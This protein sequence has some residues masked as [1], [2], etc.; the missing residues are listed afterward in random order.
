MVYQKC[1]TLTK[2]CILSKLNKWSKTKENLKR[3]TKFN[4]N[5]G[6][7][8]IMTKHRTTFLLS[9]FNYSFR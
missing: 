5:G 3:K 1:N 7:K 8:K 6:L 9:I 2:V 4:G